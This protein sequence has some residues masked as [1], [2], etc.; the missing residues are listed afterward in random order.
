MLYYSSTA[1]FFL[2][3]TSC[4]MQTK[5]FESGYINREQ[6]NSVSKN[7]NR[8]WSFDL[9]T[10]PL[11]KSH[12]TERTLVQDYEVPKH[13]NTSKF[14]QFVFSIAVQQRTIGWSIVC[15]YEIKTTFIS[16]FLL[17]FLTIKRK[18]TIFLIYILRQWFRKFAGVAAL[19]EYL[20]FSISVL[21]WII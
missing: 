6:H 9:G 12:K 15:Y 13:P 14:Q 2:S 4:S 17:S 16:C 10:R 19:K 21:W 7:L 8:H 20:K 3:T 5:I 1:N 18:I 11:I